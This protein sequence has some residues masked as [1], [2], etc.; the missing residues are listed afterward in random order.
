MSPMHRILLFALLLAV[1]TPAA[2]HA[3]RGEGT[4]NRQLEQ[5]SRVLIESFNRL[6]RHEFRN[7]LA[8]MELENASELARRQNLGGAFSENRSSRFPMRPI[9]MKR[10]GSAG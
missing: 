5:L 10:S 6:E 7:R 1:S 9:R 3:Q 2:L 4:I 8:V